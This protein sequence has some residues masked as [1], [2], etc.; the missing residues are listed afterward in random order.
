M[1]RGLNLSVYDLQRVKDNLLFDEWQFWLYPLPHTQCL[2]LAYVSTMFLQG[3]SQ[4]LNKIPIQKP[5]SGGEGGGGGGRWGEGGHAFFRN[6]LPFDGEIRR[7]SS[8]TLM[9]LLARILN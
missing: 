3:R 1:G 4:Q 8:R 2:L 5:M 9:T 6:N 7:N